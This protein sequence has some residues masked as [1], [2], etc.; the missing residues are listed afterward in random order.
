MEL[1]IQGII[2]TLQAEDLDL[3][4]KFPDLLEKEEDIRVKIR[5]NKKRRGEI[6]VFIEAYQKLLTPL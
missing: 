5:K 1:D 2:V 4:I 3:E 6:S